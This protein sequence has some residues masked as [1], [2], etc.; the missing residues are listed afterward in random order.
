MSNNNN[1]SSG[2]IGFFGL[3]TIVFIV[4]KLTNYVDWL[5]WWVLCPLWGP[6]AIGITVLFGLFLHGKL[7]I[8]KKIEKTGLNYDEFMKKTNEPPKSKWQQRFEDMQKANKLRE[9]K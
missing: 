4:L 8:R 1:N 7:T 2:S 9:N 5:W 3:L 6:A